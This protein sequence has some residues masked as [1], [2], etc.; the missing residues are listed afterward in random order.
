MHWSA[1]LVEAEINVANYRERARLSISFSRAPVAID[2]SIH[3]CMRLQYQL[4]KIRFSS[5]TLN[6]KSPGHAVAWEDGKED[7]PESLYK[8]IAEKLTYTRSRL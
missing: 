2:S 6:E 1:A 8:L 7:S 5:S 3:K 4:F